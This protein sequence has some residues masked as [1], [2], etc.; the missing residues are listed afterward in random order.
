MKIAVNLLPFREKIAGAG[1]YAQKIM[2][3]LS[4]IDKSNQYIL[5]ISEQGKHNFKGLS[6]NFQFYIAAFN[7]EKVVNR[8]FW[9]QLVFPRKLK[10]LKADIVFTPSV[11]IPIFSKGIFFTTI[12]DLAYKVN[13]YKYSLIRRKYVELVTLIAAKK[14]NTIFT[15]SNFSKKA[16]EKEFNLKNKKVLVTYNGV[17]ENF[18]QDYSFE[19]KNNF[20]RKYKLPENY[21]LYVGAIEPGKN[22]DKLFLAL[23]KIFFEKNLNSYLV[24]TSGI[25]WGQELLNNLIKELDLQD[26]VIKLPYISDEE[27]PLLYKCALMLVYLSSYEGFGIP[28]LESLASGTPVLT[29]KSEAIIEFAGNSVLSVNPENLTEIIEGIILIKTNN[30]VRDE[31]TKRGRII[32]RNYHWLN[33]AKIIYD[34]IMSRNN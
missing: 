29:S 34:E 18:Y 7:P 24:L 14:S 9:E 25:G 30:S 21:L 20:R 13:K 33:S 5:F 22:L 27:M 3:Y 6:S 10:Q 12:H 31:L 8:I 4:E 23:A 19:E 17:G 26:R 28:V 2:Q 16:I 1:K 11:A 32:A 15:V